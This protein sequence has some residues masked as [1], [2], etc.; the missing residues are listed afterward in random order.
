M[1]S[2]SG[3]EDL[4][5]SFDRSWLPFLLT[6]L[7]SRE[8]S[9]RWDGIYCVRSRSHIKYTENWCKF[10]G[11]EWRIDVLLLHDWWCCLKDRI[12]FDSDASSTTLSLY[13]S[14]WIQPQQRDLLLPRYSVGQKQCWTF[15]LYDM[16]LLNSIVVS[17]LYHPQ[18]GGSSPET[19]LRA[20]CFRTSSPL[21]KTI[22][23]SCV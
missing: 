11:I 1:K 22:K 9:E 16:V 23:S 4:S 13:L 6:L 18:V 5:G 19:K 3:R 20:Q 7:E 21:T 12:T 10:T 2:R 15:N 8:Q 14:N 17:P